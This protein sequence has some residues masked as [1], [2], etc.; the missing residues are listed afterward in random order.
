MGLCEN[1]YRRGAVY[2]WR[3]RFGAKGQGSR[4]VAL[5]LRTRDPDRARSLGAR[6]NGLAIG[7]RQ[8][9]RAGAMSI[10]EVREHF[11][12]V[13]PGKRFYFDPSIVDRASEADADRETRPSTVPYTLD[14]ERVMLAAFGRHLAS[15]S[16]A[17]SLGQ[18]CRRR[19]SQP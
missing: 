6:L 10:E 18:E 13:A 8:R 11:I 14:R 19:R 2:W 16:V 17:D 12:E 7:G 9:V 3:G 4:V 5:S 15:G 1:V